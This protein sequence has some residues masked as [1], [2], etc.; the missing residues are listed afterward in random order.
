M[1]SPIQASIHLGGLSSGGTFT[2]YAASQLNDIL[3]SVA[4][5]ASSP[6][7]GFGDVPLDPPI[8]I[9]GFNGLQD[10]LNPYD[11]NSTAAEGL[12]PYDTVVSGGGL[13]KEQ[14]RNS[15]VIKNIG[16]VSGPKLGQT[17]KDVSICFQVVHT[18]V[19]RINAGSA[20]RG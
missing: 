14:G 1:W 18:Q 11:V 5:V 19:L 12:G 8:S 3:A 17:F 20:V 13:Y 10:G 4:P 16:P 2:H 7:L 6:L 15:I 9:M